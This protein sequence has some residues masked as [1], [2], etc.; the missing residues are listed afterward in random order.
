MSNGR[1]HVVIVTRLSEELFLQIP[2]DNLS[3]SK[4]EN[5]PFKTSQAWFFIAF[6]RDF[7]N[8]GY[9]TLDAVLIAISNKHPDRFP[10]APPEFQ[11]WREAL[12][13]QNG[14]W[15]VPTYKTVYIFPSVWKYKHRD[16][17]IG[18]ALH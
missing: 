15:V 17:V 13:S 5:I 16:E 1:Q 7:F 4:P 8:L 2:G 14:L 11:S 6:H 18:G 10:S 9:S 12:L 3:G